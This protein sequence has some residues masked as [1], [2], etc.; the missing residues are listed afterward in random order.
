MGSFLLAT[1]AA[2]GLAK[3]TLEMETTVVFDT[4]RY[5]AAYNR[6]STRSRSCALMYVL[7]CDRVPDTQLFEE[8]KSQ[9]GLDKPLWIS[10]RSQTSTGKSRVRFVYDQLPLHPQTGIIAAR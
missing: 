8:W 2:E 1:D 9:T 7:Q 5:I 6:M 3:A 4:H 10:A